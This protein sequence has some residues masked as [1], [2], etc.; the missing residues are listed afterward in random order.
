MTKNYLLISN[1]FRY[2]AEDSVLSL[3]D[4][5]VTMSKHSKIPLVY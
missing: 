4:P 1:W 5:V 3:D 2:I